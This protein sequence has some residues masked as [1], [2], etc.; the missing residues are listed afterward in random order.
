MK[1]AIYIDLDGTLLNDKYEIS[2]EDLKYLKSIK[3]EYDIILTTGK[4]LKNSLRYYEQLELNTY[5][6]TSQGQVIT[7][8]SKNISIIKTFKNTFIKDILK[9]KK[10]INFMIELENI[11][12][13]KI[14]DSFVTKMVGGNFKLYEGENHLNAIGL[15]IETTKDFKAPKINGLRSYE[16][17]IEEC[18]KIISYRP[19]D[20]SKEAA[21]KYI[22]KKM[23]YQTTISIGN[24]RNDIKMFKCSDISISMINSH[25]DVLNTTTYT[26]IYDNNNSG[27]SRSLKNIIKAL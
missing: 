24:G 20:S 10:I 6:S 23:G 12:L 3:S 9:N 2:N 8:P 14:F 21:M 1:K 16:W 4:S 17:E 26:S 7:L 11:K 22:N 19:L 27:V 15:Y 18:N 5:F 13:V 25:P